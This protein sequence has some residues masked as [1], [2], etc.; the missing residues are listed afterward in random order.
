MMRPSL[1]AAVLFALPALSTVACHPRSEATPDVPSAPG[2]S[3]PLST[4][5]AQPHFG[6]MKT[7]V[8]TD[9]GQAGDGTPLTPKAGDE[10]AAFAEGCFWGSENTFR[11]VEGVVAT[12]VGYT[13][14]HTT[15]PSYEDVCT[16]T[17]GHAETVLVEFDPKRVT[18]AQLL[19]A[20]WDTHDPTTLNRQ[21]PDVGDQYRSAIFTFSPEQAAEVQRSTAE[22]QKQYTRKI[23][24]DVRPMGA[25]WKAEGYHQQYD[26]KTG[27][28]SCPIPKRR[29][30]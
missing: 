6:V 21:G 7:S 23:T 26:E 5:T 10:L 24:T 8:G 4:D 17:T 12:A 3:S 14:G 20:F 16:H 18:Y 27:R 9:P 1:L 13:G 11:H 22:E 25:F 19:R 28:E 30:S 29:G 15:H 2:P